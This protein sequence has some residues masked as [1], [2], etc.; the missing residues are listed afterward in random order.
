VIY[1][2]YSKMCKKAEVEHKYSTK[3]LEAWGRFVELSPSSDAQRTEIEPL[4]KQRY[5][6]Y[7]GRIVQSK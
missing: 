3:M 2:T 7:L 1:G 5:N 4:V 6:P